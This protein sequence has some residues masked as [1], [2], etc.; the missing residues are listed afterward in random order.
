MFSTGLVASVSIYSIVAVV[1]TIYMYK[2]YYVLH[3]T[4][5]FANMLNTT[6]T[7]CF[8]LLCAV[9]LVAWRVATARPRPS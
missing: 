8:S 9:V 4:P 7:A 3:A 6:A 1:S 5:Y 2:E